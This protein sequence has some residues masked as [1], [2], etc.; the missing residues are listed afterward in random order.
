MASEKLENA[1]DYERSP[2]FTEAERAA[3][4]F[5]QKAA[6]VPNAVEDADIPELSR[7][8][9]HDEITEILAVVALLGFPECTIRRN[10]SSSRP[11]QKGQPDFMSAGADGDARN[12]IEPFDPDKHDR[13]AFSCGVEQVDNYLKNTANKLA[14]ADNVRLYVMTTRGGELIGFC[15]INAHAVDYADLPKK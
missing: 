13:T 12:L 3:M 14:K 1:W 5:S 2:L 4:R 7:W 10:D 11:A 8:Y 9:D 6:S 15:A